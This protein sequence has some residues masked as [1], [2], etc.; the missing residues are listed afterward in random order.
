MDWLVQ[1]WVW[2]LAFAAFI[3]F[4]LRRHDTLWSVGKAAG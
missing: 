3:A 2:V 1:D 4:L